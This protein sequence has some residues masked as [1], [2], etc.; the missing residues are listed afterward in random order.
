MTLTDIVNFGTA[1][2]CGAVKGFC[3]GRGIDL[4]AFEYIVPITGIVTMPTII[5]LIDSKESFWKI[6]C[7][8]AVLTGVGYVAGRTGSYI[9]DFYIKS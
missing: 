2:G 7:I 4:H 8:S 6:S 3:D 5:K 9:F 1:L